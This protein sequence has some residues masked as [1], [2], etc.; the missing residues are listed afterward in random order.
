MP[1]QASLEYCSSVPLPQTEIKLVKRATPDQIVKQLNKYTHT[2]CTQ[3][4]HVTRTQKEDVLT[5]QFE[6]VIHK[7]CQQTQVRFV[8][9]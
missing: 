8:G 4:T 1:C 9:F 2:H 6:I 3:S 7:C 5:L